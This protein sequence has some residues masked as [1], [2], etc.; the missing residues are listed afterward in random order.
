MK[1]TI[2]SLLVVCFAFI[3]RAQS[4][5]ESGTVST[6]GSKFLAN[7]VNRTAGTLAFDYGVG[8]LTTEGYLIPL[9]YVTADGLA[10]GESTGSVPFDLSSALRGRDGVHRLVPIARLDEK[11]PWFITIAP[12]ESYVEAEVVSGIVSLSNKRRQEVIYSLLVPTMTFSSTPTADQ[13][14]T[15][16]VEVQNMGNTSFAGTLYLLATYTGQMRQ[17]GLN[18]S[19][20]SKHDF[21]VEY[22]PATGGNI[23][24]TLSLDEKGEKVV[25]E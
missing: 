5:I 16:T 2:L 8:I 6:Y 23:T 21:S 14:T 19:A 10:S 20:G 15:I 24:F 4:G 22:T 3:V 11:A 25:Y 13:P 18:L 12:K 7:Y 1:K 17:E 9:T